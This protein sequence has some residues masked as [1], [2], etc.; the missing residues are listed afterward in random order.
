ME[1]FSGDYAARVRFEESAKTTYEEVMEMVEILVARGACD[2]NKSNH[3][4]RRH[5]NGEDPS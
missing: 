2:C 3:S 1:G 5:D 4:H